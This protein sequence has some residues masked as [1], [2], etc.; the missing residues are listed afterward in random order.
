MKL[1]FEEGTPY[2]GV[3]YVNDRMKNCLLYMPQNT[4]AAWGSKSQIFAT[5]KS[6]HLFYWFHLLKKNWLKPV[7]EI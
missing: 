6:W 5:L 7:A 1:T 3:M 4:N 2:I